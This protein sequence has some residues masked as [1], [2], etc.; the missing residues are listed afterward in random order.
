MPAKSVIITT[1]SLNLGGA[2]T[3]V[4]SLAKELHQRGYRVTVASSGG[5]YVPLLHPVPHVTIPLHSRLPHKLLGGRRL[6]GR[7][8]KSEKPQLLHAHGRIPAWVCQHSSDKLDIPLVTTHHGVYAS[9]LPWKWVTV[10]GD[11]TIAVSH[12]VSDHLQAAFG[13]RPE[14]I[15]II[16]NGI[17]LSL[18]KPQAKPE[19]ARQL[20]LDG[21]T[22]IISHLSRLDGEFADTALCLISACEQ[23]LHRWPDLQLVIAGHGNRMKE[24]RLRAQ[25][26]RIRVHL[27]GALVD[28]VPVFNT[29]DVVVAVART[30]MEALACQRPV[31]I[32]GEGGLVGPLTY[33]NQ[34]ALEEANF[35][36]RTLGQELNADRMSCLIDFVLGHSTLREEMA[37]LGR[38]LIEKKHSIGATTEAIME[39]YDNVIQSHKKRWG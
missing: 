29:A 19:A 26:A 34:T 20:E 1:M 12:D 11:H 7:L 30:A 27:L 13:F 6:F 37:Q 10:P 2:E 36:A 4:V 25:E 23:L 5:Q 28:T 24:V 14:N 31:I 18:Y 8:V 32:A 21:D 33:A 38:P 16:P 17:D 35:T 9:G 39:V 15:T 3:H 22:T